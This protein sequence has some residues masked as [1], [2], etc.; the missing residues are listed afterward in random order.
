[1]Q[2]NIIHLEGKDAGQ[3]AGQM[4]GVRRLADLV[5]KGSVF[6]SIYIQPTCFSEYFSK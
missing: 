6:D 3:E 1:M 5:N 2:Q 4:T